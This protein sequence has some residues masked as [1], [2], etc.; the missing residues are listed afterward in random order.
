[1]PFGNKFRLAARSLWEPVSV[2]KVK[3]ALESLRIVLG[4]EWQ[5][6]S[7]VVLPCHWHF[8]GVHERSFERWG[9]DPSPIAAKHLDKLESLYS[10][11]LTRHWTAC[12]WQV[13]LG[14]L[15]LKDIASKVN[16]KTVYE[17]MISCKNSCAKSSSVLQ[18]LSRLKFVL[19]PNICL[20]PY[21]E[22]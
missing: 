17:Y 1:M 3:T 2:S 8:T 16:N 19:F 15:F 9:G 4:D 20:A 14:A 6:G 11:K 18:D 22:N 5:L 13:L 10:C 7:G 21:V 12:S